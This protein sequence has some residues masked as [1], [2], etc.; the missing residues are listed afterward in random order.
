MRVTL[1]GQSS[2]HGC[3][4]YFLWRASVPWLS[5]ILPVDSH[6][7]TVVTSTS[8]GQPFYHGCHFYF[9]WTIILP[10]LLLLLPVDSQCTMVVTSTSCGQPFYHGCYFSYLSVWRYYLSRSNIYT[11]VQGSMYTLNLMRRKFTLFHRRTT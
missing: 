2:F 10:W 3:Y 5:L 1:C 7:T 11:E 8:C 9:L 4:F 6:S